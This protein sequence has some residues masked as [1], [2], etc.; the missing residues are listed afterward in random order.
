M[1]RFQ[2]IINNLIRIIIIAWEE[3][4]IILLG[5]FVTSFFG[6]ILMFV[7][8]YAYKLLIDQVTINLGHSPTTL[9][10]I[11]VVTYLF[12]EYLSRFAYSTINLYYY[13]TLE[14]SKIQ[15]AL[16]RKFMAK[17]ADL[18]FA[19]LENGDVRNLIARVADTYTWRL[20]ESLQTLNGLIYSVFGLVFA[21]FISLRFNILYFLLLAAVTTP[22]Y[23]L[24]SRY[25]S[26]AYSIY[27]SNSPLTNYL[28]YMRNLFTNFQT[29]SEMKLYQLKD[30]FLKRTEEIQHKLL[31]D[32]RRPIAQY[33]LFSVFTSVLI[34]I[35]IFFTILNFFNSAAGRKYSIGDF[36]FFLNTLFA[37]SSQI[38]SIL[39]NVGSI[40][41]NSLFVDDY[42][43]LLAIKNT[44][45]NPPQPYRFPKIEPREIKFVDVSFNYPNSGKL[46]LKKINLTVNKMEDVAIVG[47]NGAG[48]TTLIKLL[49]RFY[50]PTSGVILIDGIDL[51][52]ID[53]NDWYQHIG[54]LFQDFARYD[55]TLRENVEFGDISRSKSKSHLF[56][57]SINK[58]QAA[59]MVKSLPRGPDQ[60]LG[61]WFEEGQELSTGQWQK[62]AIARALYRSAPILILDEPTSNIDAEAEYEIFDNLKK[63]YKDK[64]LVFIS[65]RFSTVRMADKI[66]VLEDG[67]II[68]QGTHR[69]LLEE[70][71]IYAR[72]FNIQKRGY[73]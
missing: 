25:S 47:H 6:V 36:T 34:P 54:V 61:R 48:K 33:S 68:E 13:A 38:A 70:A 30:Y 50:D 63:T 42:F 55:L 15:N 22:L 45:I 17:L 53:I 28:W 8:F 23:Y 64:S 26:A 66:Y 57:E 40:Y 71:G 39:F 52:Q 73:E 60:I 19:H 67:Q 51:R 69:K 59:D 72:Y 5:Y 14:R 58:A 35:A 44:V 43:N 56:H 12:F 37:F 7:V 10:L 21:F 16:T 41:E 49:L 24:R 65:H 46:A 20:P 29:L 1:S 62:V 18:D 4:R 3:D 2:K 11:V 9:L 32:F 31:E 27:S